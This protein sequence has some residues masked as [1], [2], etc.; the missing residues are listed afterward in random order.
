MSHLWN[1]PVI[2]IH[3][4]IPPS[5]LREDTSAPA[6][7]WKAD[8]KFLIDE[9][10]KPTNQPQRYHIDEITFQVEWDRS[11][12]SQF[13]I[14]VPEATPLTYS[15]LKLLQ[16]LA[17][18]RGG[19]DRLVAVATYWMN[20]NSLVQAYKA[21]VAPPVHMNES[22]NAPGIDTGAS[23]VTES[24]LRKH[25]AVVKPSNTAVRSFADPC[26]KAAF[27]S[28]ENK[29]VT[30]RRG[31]TPGGRPQDFRT[32][33]SGVSGL[34]RER[35]GSSKAKQTSGG[36]PRHQT[37]LSPQQIREDFHNRGKDTTTRGFLA[38]SESLVHSGRESVHARADTEGGG[39]SSEGL[40]TGFETARSQVETAFNQ[41][42]SG[43]G[44]DISMRKEN[45]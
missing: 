15:N 35:E 37:S 41:A 32:M 3:H 5:P 4:S 25:V 19:K 39:T 29:I 43:Q 23:S 33:A 27:E 2:K 44:W 26:V 17:E 18:K 16:T 1:A 36:A 34:Q 14:E 38:E 22:C 45:K 42:A 7:S 9:I 28:Q 21:A 12:H 40:G 20:R 11:D 8:L 24:H 30:P 6:L 31:A 13:I 10:F